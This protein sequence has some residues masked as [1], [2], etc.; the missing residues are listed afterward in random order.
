MCIPGPGQMSVS[1]GLTVG[2]SVV[3]VVL[4]AVAG[5]AGV[6]ENTLV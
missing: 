6:T 5:V 1:R 2:V 4:V 3:M